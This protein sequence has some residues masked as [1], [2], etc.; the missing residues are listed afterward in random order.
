MAEN[1][2]ITLDWDTTGLTVYCIIRREVDDFRM[3]DAD[4]SFAASPADP[5]A[6]LIEDTV[7]KGRYE[8][9]E[10]RTVWDN[11]RYTIAIYNQ[12]SGSPAPASD[13]II[14]T[15]ELSIKDDLEVIL[16]APAATEATLDA[17]ET[18]RASMQTDLE[19]GHA[20][21]LAQVTGA[22]NRVITIHVQDTDTNNLQ[23]VLVRI[24]EAS[25]YTDVNGDAVFALDDGDYDVILRKNFVSF[26]VPESLT[27]SG[28]G[29]HPY[30]GTLIVPSA[31][32]QP[33]TCVVF[34]TVIDDSGAVVSGAKISIKET[35]DATFSNTQKLIKTTET[36]SD[37]N[38]FW[39]LEKIRS[40]DLAPDTSPY[41][42]II[43][44]G[45]TGFRFV[46]SITVPDADSVE[47]STIVNT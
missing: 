18:A 7:I 36:I 34:G 43:T 45:D 22:G 31:P 17:H 37:P 23:D 32:T 33:D 3:D 35:N 16:S 20:A 24:G 15:G 11:G 10:A 44:Y 26:T 12:A 29:T 5:Y 47:F 46:T 39:E 4:G 13:T 6:G 2:R 1:K 21:I 40:S 42:A 9:D 14:G 27:V 28:D 25:Q 19:A 8:L 38:G 41:E 30:T